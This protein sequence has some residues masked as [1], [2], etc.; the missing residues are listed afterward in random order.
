MKDFAGKVAVV[1]GGASGIG[2]AVA[3]RLQ[4]AGMTLV[5]ADF[6][7]DALAAAQEMGALGI[8]TD[9]SRYEDMEG[10]A[11]EVKA[12]FG[13]CHLI[14]NNAGVG[15]YAAF[16]RL[17]MQD[18]RWMFDV[19]F[20]GAV[21]GVK[22]FMPLLRANADGGHI[23]NTA[24]INGLHVLPGGAAYGATKHALVGF[25]DTLAL[26]LGLEGVPIGVTCFCPGPVH[27]NIPTSGARRDVARY[28]APPPDPT[29]P[30]VVTKAF[31][32]LNRDATISPEAAAEV[33]FEALQA[34]RFWAI[35]HPDLLEP[36]AQRYQD[37]F[38]A[39]GRRP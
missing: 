26:E 27:T 35:T 17:S 34:E 21:H 37:I 7:E 36:V 33:L 3:E 18:W 12:R 15:V 25:S 8:R 5:I 10:L 28:G 31:E 30:D 32:S 13:T 4:R 14:V 20:W 11:A 9:V 38:A 19:N 39:V 16:E 22:A 1:T 6:D 23:V 2:R 29:R 24:S